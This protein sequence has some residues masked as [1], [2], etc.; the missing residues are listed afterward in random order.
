[1]EYCMYRPL[2]CDILPNLQ[3]LF[4]HL[5]AKKL[6]IICFLPHFCL[7]LPTNKYEDNMKYREYYISLLTSHAEVLKKNFGVKTLRL[8][9]SVSRNEQKENSDVDV[10][11]D[12]E[13]K[14][15]LVVRLKRFL[16]ELLQCSVD[17][18]RMHNHINPFLLK[19]IEQDGIYVIKT[20]IQVLFEI[21][22]QKAVSSTHFLSLY[23]IYSIPSNLLSA[24]GSSLL[25][26][27]SERCSSH[28]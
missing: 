22:R 20:L 5:F 4:L 11:V 1:M 25:P 9:G 18:V 26:L 13:P 3:A 14:M 27:L 23:P 6:E 12:M 17:V 15:F 19:E 7:S 24:A 16:E 8:F 21:E 28:Y 2:H 10:C